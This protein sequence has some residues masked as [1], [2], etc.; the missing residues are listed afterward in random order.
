MHVRAPCGHGHAEQPRSDHARLALVLLAL[1]LLGADGATRRTR[2]HFTLLR[3][4]RDKTRE[5]DTVGAA[6]EKE[7]EKDGGGDCRSGV[8]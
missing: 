4:A 2:M 3:S 7:A 6:E 5:A 1:W 8:E